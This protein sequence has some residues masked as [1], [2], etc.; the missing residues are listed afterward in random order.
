M[1][2]KFT[3]IQIIKQWFYVPIKNI[4]QIQALDSSYIIRFIPEV[5]SKNNSTGIINH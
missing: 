1:R 3:N 5:I 4:I 2:I